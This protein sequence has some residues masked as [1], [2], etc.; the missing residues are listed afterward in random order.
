MIS[1]GWHLPAAKAYHT[2]NTIKGPDLSLKMTIA[3]ILRYTT[4][5]VTLYFVVGEADK[6]HINALM[7]PIKFW[8][9]GLEWSFVPLDATKL[10]E[11]MA[12]IGHRPSHRTGMAGN[13]KF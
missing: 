6:A 11:W 8:R 9:A 5:P 1:H 13:I 4:N 7:A 3:G 2:P 10:D 12:F